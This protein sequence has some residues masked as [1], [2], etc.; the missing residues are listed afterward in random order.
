MG[1]ELI[2]EIDKVWM[3]NNPNEMQ[4][5]L[6]LLAEKILLEY[7][8][9]LNESLFDITEIEFYI[10]KHDHDDPFVHKHSGFKTGQF[11]IHGA[12]IDIALGDEENYGGI[13][14]RSIRKAGETQL[15]PSPIK[16]CDAIIANMGDITKS[17]IT[18]VKR[19]AELNHDIISTPRIGLTPK[20]KD[21]TTD[22]AKFLVY[23]YRFFT[24]DDLKAEKYIKAICLDIQDGLDTTTVSEYKK[25]FQEG[26]QLVNIEPIINGYFN[27]HSKVKLMGYFS[28]QR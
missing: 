23:N 1:K 28:N 12:G 9:K 2:T 15:I 3:I 4:N 17:S 19:A 10:N 18:I 22:Q 20:G 26:L 13:L 25:S 27:L 14:L 6:S 5:Y 8:L 21:I 24:H 11:R 16:V 7:Q